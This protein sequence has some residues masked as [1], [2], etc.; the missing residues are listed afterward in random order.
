M[1]NHTHRKKIV[2]G[3]GK[4]ALALSLAVA[5]A[6]PGTAIAAAPAAEAIHATAGAETAAGDAAKAAAIA[7]AGGLEK[8]AQKTDSLTIV[9]LRTVAEALGAA[10]SWNGEERSVTVEKGT[11]LIQVKIGDTKAL[12]NGQEAELGGQALLAE[13]LTMVPLGFLREV[14]GAQF[15]WDGSRGIIVPEADD[16]ETRAAL[17]LYLLAQGRAAEVYT[18]ASEALKGHVDEKQ[19]VAMTA[20]I[21]TLLSVSAKQ[22]SSSIQTNAVHDNVIMNYQS[23]NQPQPMDVEIRFDK[24]G[25]LDDLNLVS[26]MVST[27]QRADYDQPERYTEREVTVGGSLPLPG[28]LTMPKGEGPFPA[29]VLVHGSG[30]NDRDETAFGSKPLKD[31]AGGLASRG[32]AV[33]RYEKVNRE[34]T[35]KI[36]FQPTYS[37]KDETV[38]DAVAGAQLLKETPDIDPGRIFVAGHSQGGYAMPLI[39]G[40]DKSGLIKG[41]VLIS[42]PSG[43]LVDVLVEQQ[44]EV[45]ERLRNSDQPE[46][47]VAAQE[48]TAA[49][50]KGIVDLIKSPSYSKDNLPKDFPLGTPYW[51]YEQRDYLPAAQAVSQKTPLFIIQG[52]NDWQVTMKQFEGWKEALKDRSNVSFKSYP[53][54]NHLLSEYSKLSTGLEYTQPANVAHAIIQDIAD[55][56]LK[57]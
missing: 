48:Q 20:G 8:S 49:M 31:L 36:A 55:W 29:V 26:A 25:H 46:T 19:F 54:V 33:L 9:P 42:A 24:E 44:Y 2:S 40:E 21:P 56:I 16:L 50:I 41:A 14:L 51:W 15:N 22:L 35:A 47:L 3:K 38:A 18:E 45:L 10:V 39:L 53:H 30:A 7:T 52:E 37:L 57:Q 17:Y 43:N 23:P 4:P 12:V 34:H 27:H 5:L 1:T 32:I 13:E 11:K 6:L 28:T